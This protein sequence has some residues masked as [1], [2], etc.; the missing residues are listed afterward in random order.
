MSTEQKPDFAS[1]IIDFLASVKL[2]FFIFIILAVA[3]IAGTVLPQKAQPQVYMEL[4]GRMGNLVL[5][6]GLDDAY[7]APWFVFL[8][9]LLI[10]NLII[11]TIKRLPHVIKIVN[12]DPALDLKRFPKPQESL[13]IPGGLAEMIGRAGKLLTGK[14]GAPLSRQEP[15][16]TVLFS[17]KGAWTRYGVYVVH[18]SVLI[19]FT[20]AIISNIFGMNGTLVIHEGQSEKAAEL[21]DGSTY[22]L[23]FEVR[24]DKYTET[25]YE[26]FKNT[27]SEFRSDLSFIQNGKEAAKAVVRVNHPFEF[28]GVTFYQSFRGQSPT[29]FK[30]SMIRGDKSQ[31]V[32]LFWRKWAPLPGGG[33]AGI[34]EFREE[35]NMGG[36]YKGPFARILIEDEKGQQ[37]QLSAFAPGFSLPKG[38]GGDSHDTKF[39]I[40][41][42]KVTWYTGLQVKKDPGVWWVWIGCGLMVLGFLITFYGSHKKVWIKITPQENQRCRVELSG[43]VNKNRPAMRRLLKGLALAL[44]HQALREGIDRARDKPGAV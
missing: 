41:S 13:E 44:S 43:S 36:K 14:L 26:K 4:Y 23:G 20:G 28:G 37:H 31:E 12:Q 29:E 3:S 18:A 19:I 22:P 2:S 38:M 15:E 32:E 40:L 11:C 42:S 10:V 16:G 27:P 39:E 30:A 33:R 5:G 6:L 25:Y 35:I 17:H 34:M 1:K 24:L 8:M 9:A 7:H 21:D